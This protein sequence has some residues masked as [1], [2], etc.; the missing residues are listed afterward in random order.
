[1]YVRGNERHAQFDNLSRTTVKR[2]RLYRRDEFGLCHARSR[3]AAVAP[4]TSGTVRE[5]LAPHYQT[6]GTLAAT[7]QQ[8][9]NV[10]VGTR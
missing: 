5:H 6:I 4:L 9:V 1:M 7:I 8:H 10:M 2:A 3:S